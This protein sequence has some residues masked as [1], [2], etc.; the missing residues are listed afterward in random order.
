[1]KTIPEVIAKFANLKGS[2]FCVDMFRNIKYIENHPLA[3]PKSIVFSYRVT[4]ADSNVNKVMHGGAI[5]TLIDMTTS[6]AVTAFDRGHRNNVSIEL[7]CT[8][9]K[10][11]LLNSNIYIFCKVPK[12]GKT[13]AYVNA[14]ILPTTD[15]SDIWV[16]GNQVK[17][18]LDKPF[19]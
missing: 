16:T 2:G 3:S 11:V 12:I 17:A 14:E 7:S 8:Y 10:P 9:L 13:V 1:M 5:A 19:F 4:E 15:E 6:I 18:M